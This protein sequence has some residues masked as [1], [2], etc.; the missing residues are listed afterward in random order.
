MATMLGIS[1]EAFPSVATWLARIEARPA[2][3]KIYG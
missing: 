3:K 2:W 1:F